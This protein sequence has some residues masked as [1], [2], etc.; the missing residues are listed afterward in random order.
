MRS[1]AQHS[2]ERRS[3]YARTGKVG[4]RVRL[5]TIVKASNAIVLSAVRNESRKASKF[6]DAA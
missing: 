1:D 5:K 4:I 2:R 6:R 3:A